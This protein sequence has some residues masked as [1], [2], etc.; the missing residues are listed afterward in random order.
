MGRRA[1]VDKDKFPLNGVCRD[2]DG[3]GGL[4]NWK[5][6]FLDREGEGDFRFAHGL[7]FRGGGQGKNICSAGSRAANGAGCWRTV[8]ENVRI[9]FNFMQLS[10][11]V[12]DSLKIMTHSLHCRY[13]VGWKPG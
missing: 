6:P 11:M 3:V 5:V 4:R 13:V 12:N 7:T 2:D 10:G 8:V 1:K 9:V